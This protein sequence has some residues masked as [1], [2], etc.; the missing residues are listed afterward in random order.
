MGVIT[1]R[2]TSK[3]QIT[4]PKKIRESL[5]VVEGD[6]LIFEIDE[7]RVIIRKLPEIDL[8]WTRAIQPTLSEWEDDLDDEL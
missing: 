3:G 8:E 1:S 7:D 2:I 6:S 4:V 5:N